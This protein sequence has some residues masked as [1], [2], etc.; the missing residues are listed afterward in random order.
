MGLIMVT[1]CRSTRYWIAGRSVLIRGIGMLERR[2]CWGALGSL[3]RQIRRSIGGSI[4]FHRLG[5]LLYF[6]VAVNMEY[7]DALVVG[8]IVHLKEDYI[9]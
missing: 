3:E 7:Q 6:A 4:G 8:G 2:E 5:E 1:P 9:E